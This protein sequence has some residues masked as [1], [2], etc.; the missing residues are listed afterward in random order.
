[1]RRFFLGTE[2]AAVLEA[3]T[4]RQAGVDQESLCLLFF[5]VS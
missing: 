4:E 3:G 2:K 1:V 5:D